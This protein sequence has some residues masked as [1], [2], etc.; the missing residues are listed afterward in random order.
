MTEG[1]LCARTCHLTPGRYLQARSVGVR[2]D[3][4]GFTM[5]LI[6]ARSFIAR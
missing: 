2:L 5:I 1:I 4:Q 3:P 6:A